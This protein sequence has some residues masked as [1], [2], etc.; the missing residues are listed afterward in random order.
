MKHRLIKRF[1]ALL[2]TIP[3]LRN[4]TEHMLRNTSG[5]AT[6]GTAQQNR[7]KRRRP[8][9]PYTLYFHQWKTNYRPWDLQQLSSWRI[10]HWQGTRKPWTPSHQIYHPPGKPRKDPLLFKLNALWRQECNLAWSSSSGS[11]FAPRGLPHPCNQG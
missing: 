5:N 6:S 1:P 11:C 3:G 10:A 7:R 8:P 9:R 2:D 4:A